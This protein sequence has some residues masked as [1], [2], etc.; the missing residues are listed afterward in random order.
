MICVLATLEVTPGKRDELLAIFHWLVPHVRAEN[1]CIEYTPM[2]DAATDMTTI[3]ENVVTVVEKWESVAILKKHL[4]TPHMVEFG[5][6]AE[7]LG[8][9]MKLQIVEPGA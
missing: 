1:G 6:R 2:I 8:L 4:A 9:T 7:P 5:K 3:R